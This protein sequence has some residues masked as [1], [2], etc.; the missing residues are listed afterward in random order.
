MA[1]GT[2]TPSVAIERLSWPSPRV[3]WVC[4]H[5]SL[6][7]FASICPFHRTALDSDR[8]TSAKECGAAILS[9]LKLNV[10]RFRVPRLGPRR[11]VGIPRLQLIPPRSVESI[12]PLFL[13][14]ESAAYFLGILRFC[15]PHAIALSI[16]FLPLCI[17]VVVKGL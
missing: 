5:S 2:V 1:S 4:I 9:H 11:I 10:L 17:I 13:V 8:P 6:L 7:L 16:I 12:I 3:A 15:T 14:I